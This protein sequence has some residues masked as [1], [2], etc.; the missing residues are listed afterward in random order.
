MMFIGLVIMAA[1][2]LMLYL[3]VIDK[4][5]PEDQW[6]VACKA[7]CWIMFISFVLFIAESKVPGSEVWM[8]YTRSIGGITLLFCSFV[9]AVTCAICLYRLVVDYI[10]GYRKLWQ[11]DPTYR[12]SRLLIMGL[13]S[14]VL[15]IPFHFVIKQAVLPM[16]TAYMDNT[17]AIEQ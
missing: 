2:A 12:L 15:A 13:M 5:D 1:F 7:F 4:C 10:I 16:I 17:H 8:A 6:K 3:F 11:F 14:G 9:A